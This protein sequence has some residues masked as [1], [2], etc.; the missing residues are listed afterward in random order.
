MIQTNTEAPQNYHDDWFQARA[1]VNVFVCVLVFMGESQQAGHGG[2]PQAFVLTFRLKFRQQGA[3][4]PER[5]RRLS[6]EG[7]Q[8]G[9]PEG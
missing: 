2:M 3:G 1:V 4:R 5:L 9:Q 6:R 7:C 8:G